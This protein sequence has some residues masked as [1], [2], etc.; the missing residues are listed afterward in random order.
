MHTVD[1]CDFFPP[2]LMN[3]LILKIIFRKKGG[4]AQHNTRLFKSGH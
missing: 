4:V 3:G 1:G 2:V